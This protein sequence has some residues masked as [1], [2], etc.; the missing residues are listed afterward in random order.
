MAD[1]VA[2]PAFN[3]VRKW[4][5]GDQVSP[6]NLNDVNQVFANAIEAL[7]QS[8]LGTGGVSALETYTNV[9]GT[10]RHTRYS[11]SRVKVEA[12]SG[13]AVIGVFW[14]QF[15]R[16][17]FITYSLGSFE[18]I[19]I[20]VDDVAGNALNP[21]TEASP[22]TSA[23]L[24]VDAG[25]TVGR[26]VTVRANYFFM[27]AQTYNIS[28]QLNFA[29]DS[30]KR[31][32]IESYGDPT[33]PR[34]ILNATGYKFGI[35]FSN[36]CH[37]ASLDNII[38]RGAYFAALYEGKTNNAA[39]P[40]DISTGPGFRVEDGE[41]RAM[42]IASVTL[43]A[44]TIVAFQQNHLLNQDDYCY[45][46]NIPP[47]IP[48]ASGGHPMNDGDYKVNILSPTSVELKLSGA[49]VNSSAWPVI[50]ANTGAGMRPAHGIYIGGR[51]YICDRSEVDG[52]NGDHMFIQSYN[53]KILGPKITKRLAKLHPTGFADCL[54]ITGDVGK[55]WVVGGTY[56]ASDANCKQAIIYNGLTNGSTVTVVNAICHGAAA[57]LP[58]LGSANAQ[59]VVYGSGA[60]SLFESGIVTNGV[61]GLWMTAANMRVNDTLYI[62]ADASFQNAIEFLDVSS[63]A[64]NNRIHSLVFAPGGKGLR[65][66]GT[67]TNR[68]SGNIIDDNF[69]TKFSN[70]AAVGQDY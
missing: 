69:A 44:T 41:F 35:H 36:V 68:H 65:V 52:V 23:S 55:A 66:E 28:L 8:T 32:R 25:P 67:S 9:A 43:G 11:D 40:S 14:Q 1:L 12:L 49:N 5:I 54:Q 64:K 2:S 29:G 4:E 38:L 24:G 3:P 13:A 33:L 63:M 51:N 53:F 47:A 15:M 56:D 20:Y 42:A 16:S 70:G 60:G 58:L 30:T 45:F 46:Y 62:N 57:S 6:Q 48:I 26:N 34:A 10:F 18:T 37:T 39:T 50:P 21:G 22:K 31:I 61:F 7:R 27:R 19:S 17:D 59:N